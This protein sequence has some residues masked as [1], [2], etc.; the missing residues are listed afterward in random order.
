M[1]WISNS[2][3]S[4]PEFWISSPNQLFRAK[5]KVISKSSHSF[6][7]P[8]NQ[9]SKMILSSKIYCKSCHSSSFSTGL[10]VSDLNFHNFLPGFS[11]NPLFLYA[12]LHREV[13]II[14]QWH[15]IFAVKGETQGY[16][17]KKMDVVVL[18]KAVENKQKISTICLWCPSERCR[19]AELI[20]GVNTEYL[21]VW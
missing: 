18:E 21:G 9:Q 16:L 11:P 8:A 17:R 3:R 2:K 13:R 1:F 5:I 7:S 4:K 6:I 15:S 20:M 12:I 10:V 14:F 19:N